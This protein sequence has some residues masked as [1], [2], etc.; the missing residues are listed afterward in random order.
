MKYVAKLPTVR[1]ST[2]EWSSVERHNDRFPKP[3]IVFLL[4]FVYPFNRVA[5]QRFYDQCMILRSLID[6]GIALLECGE[7]RQGRPLFLYR[8]SHSGRMR[9]DSKQLNSSFPYLE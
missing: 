7:V 9:L 5:R 4:A 8:C 3:A 1:G 2:L 6:S